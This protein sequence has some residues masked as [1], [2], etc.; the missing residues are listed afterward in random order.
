MESMRANICASVKVVCCPRAH[1][2]KEKKKIVYRKNDFKSHET[3]RV[4][5]T[6]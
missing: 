3:K 4:V 6:F 1:D 2:Q 5:C